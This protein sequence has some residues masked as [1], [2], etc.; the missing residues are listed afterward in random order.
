MDRL[1][2]VTIIGGVVIIIL[3]ATNM[4]LFVQTM[5]MR[6]RVF[7]IMQKGNALNGEFLQKVG[8]WYYRFDGILKEMNKNG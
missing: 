8:E 5:T 4:V 2:I 1:S 3:T 6:D 7:E